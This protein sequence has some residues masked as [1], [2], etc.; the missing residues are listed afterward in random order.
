M[1]SLVDGPSQ[2]LHSIN[3]FEDD[4]DEDK[5]I[6]ISIDNSNP[7]FK[8]REMLESIEFEKKF[9]GKPNISLI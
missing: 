1:S 2:A 8:N 3:Y 4:D 9:A 7:K 5:D 6:Q